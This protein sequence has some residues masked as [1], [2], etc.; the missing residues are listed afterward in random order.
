VF[1]GF[2]SLYIVLIY[3][4]IYSAAQL[5]ECLINLLTYLRTDVNERTTPDGMARFLP[6]TSMYRLL[7]IGLNK[8][9][10]YLIH[11]VTHRF[12]LIH[13]KLF[14]NYRK[15]Y[16]NEHTPTACKEPISRSY[17]SASLDSKSIFI[18]SLPNTDQTICKY[19]CYILRNFN[20]VVIFVAN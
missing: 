13:T 12:M 5:Q 15:M 4:L 8:T 19:I 18:A 1:R 17:L 20:R 16:K 11:T 3:V 10:R 9:K 14:K 2:L 6:V 7:C